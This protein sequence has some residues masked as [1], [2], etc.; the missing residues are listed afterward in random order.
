[1]EL[2]DGTKP[3]LLIFDKEKEG[4]LNTFNIGALLKK[5]KDAEE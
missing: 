3:P 1:M 2:L 5:I 4:R